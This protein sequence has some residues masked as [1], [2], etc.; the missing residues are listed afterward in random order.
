[1]VE[2]IG[3]QYIRVCSELNDWIDA[4]F[5]IVNEKEVDDAVKVLSKFYDR[6]WEEETECYGDVLE[7]GLI[8]ANI[9]FKSFYIKTDERGEVAENECE[10]VGQDYNLILRDSEIYLKV[11]EYEPETD[12]KEAVVYRRF[13][14]QGNI[15][16]NEDAYKNRPDEVCYVPELTD[17]AYTAKDFL[18][19][20]C[21]QK[22]FADEL[23]GSC[24][25]QHPESLQEDWVR[26]GEWAFCRECKKFYDIQ[27]E[28]IENCPV[29]GTEFD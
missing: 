1:M 8:V 3:I 10:F 27:G 26:N 15:Y 11:G 9:D 28:D 17:E 19:M 5:L 23:F 13:Y 25:W 24:D 4:L 2:K 7:A 18:D 14:G 16:K 21:G 12:D 29:C 20:C 22:E 6:Y